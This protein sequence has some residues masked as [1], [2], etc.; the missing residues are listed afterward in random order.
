MFLRNAWYIAA[1]A[2]EVAA[3]QLLGRKLLNEAVV[4]FRD[5]EGKVAALEDR[6][7]HRAAALSMGS[8]TE[9]G[10]MC[11]YH[12]LVF[13][14]RGVCVD[15]PGQSRIPER[16]RVKSY[17]VVEKNEFV[18]I[19]MGQEDKADPAL[20]VD[21]P[22][23]DDHANWPHKHAVLPVKCN[24][25]LLIDNLMDLTHLGYVHARTIGGDPKTHIDAKMKV[26][27][28]DHGV[29]YIRWMLDAVPPP[30][31]AQA[32][33]FKGRIDRWQEFEYYAPGNIL[34]FSGALDAGT[35]A[36]DQGKREGGFALR[37]F[38]GITPETE[39]SCFYFWTA[40]NG[41]RT[42]DPAA[43]QELHD[44]IA[45]TFNEDKVFV[46]EQQRRLEGFDTTR[47]IDI[48]SDGPRLQM[49]RYLRKLIAEEHA[50]QS[51]AAE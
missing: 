48:D 13:D 7:C 9:K 10:L 38:H 47:L 30:T 6:C 35:G 15:I 32:V 37:V 16:A 29:K 39:N 28:A 1:W 5:T 45:F 49:S 34:Q 40:A 26:S 18:W 14:G 31:Y 17:P 19:W 46:E 25:L 50:L 27:K 2:N 36:Y 41:Y 12:G 44:Q 43:T 24:Y 51:V 21:Y 8:V 20:I 11:G 3:G 42:D 33:G 23:N 4:L 22:F